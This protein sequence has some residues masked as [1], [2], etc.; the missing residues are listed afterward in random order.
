MES[1]TRPERERPR[2]LLPSTACATASPPWAGPPP[3]SWPTPTCG[4]SWTPRPRRPRTGRHLAAGARRGRLRVPLSVFG[5]EDDPGMPPRRLDAWS[6]HV[7][8][9]VE[10]HSLPGGHFYFVGSI[11]DVTGRITRDVRAALAAGV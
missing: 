1:R 5:G 2:H 10:R 8:G 4:G 9:P 7:D 6:D 3:R 11:D